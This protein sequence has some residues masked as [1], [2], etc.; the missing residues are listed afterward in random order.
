MHNCKRSI[1]GGSMRKTGIAFL[2]LVTLVASFPSQTAAKSS[3]VQL[4][5]EE[6]SPLVT[7]R[8]IG[9]QLPDGAR[10]KG[11][12]I[13]VRDDSLYMDVTKTSNKLSYPKGQLSIPRASVAAMD[14]RQ[15]KKVRG[16]VIGTTV[17]VVGGVFAAAAVAVGLCRADTCG[18]A[19]GWGAIG[20]GVGIAVLGNRLGHEADMDKMTIQIIRN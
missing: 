10:L 20:A 11:D 19:A 7:G 5:W 18:A 17:G 13:T 12:V 8:E 16:R 2:L 14:L 9:I 1:A 6:L 3:V 4:R 15:I